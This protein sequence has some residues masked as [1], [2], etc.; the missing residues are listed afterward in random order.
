MNE[1]CHTYE[2]VMSHLWMSHVTHMDESCHTHTCQTDDQMFVSTTEWVM[3]HTNK[4]CH[5]CKCQRDK[6]DACGID[7][8]S[9]VTHMNES[10][11]TYEWDMSHTWMSHV[12]HMNES[13]DTYEWIC[14][15]C[16][17]ESCHMSHIRMS[18]VTCHTY[19]WV[20]SHPDVCILVCVFLCLCLCVCE[21][22]RERE[23]E[24]NQVCTRALH[25]WFR[26]DMTH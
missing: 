24:Q 16:T 20:T 5:T 11:H 7:P 6:L 1:S 26:G 10:C 2:W 15:T 18:S 9:H 13:R 17:N 25:T 23:R 4:S 14:F 19:N 21:W 22:E 3:S 12:T 8:M